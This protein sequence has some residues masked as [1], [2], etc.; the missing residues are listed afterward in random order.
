MTRLSETIIG[1]AT[2]S[3]KMGTL[4]AQNSNRVRDKPK[5]GRPGEQRKRTAN[6][7]KVV[8]TDTKKNK[9]ANKQTA[10]EIK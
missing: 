2:D 8:N 4:F 9:T 6:T 1:N 3:L 7:E 5:K 10:N